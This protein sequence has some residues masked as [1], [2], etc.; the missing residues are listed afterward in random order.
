MTAD[1]RNPLRYDCEKSGCFNLI[2]RARLE[3]FADC[4]PGRISMGDVD[5]IVEINGRVL[6]ME[7]KGLNAGAISMGQRILHERLSA[8]PKVT[9]ILVRGDPQT[10]DVKELTVMRNGKALPTEKID[11]ARLKSRIA[12]WART[13]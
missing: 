4:F 2:M 12:A 13:A 7:W 10:M 1:G 11:L 8:I 5:G 3:E 6:F 9:V